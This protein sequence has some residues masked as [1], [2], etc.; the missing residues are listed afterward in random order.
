MRRFFSAVLLCVAFGGLTGCAT[1]GS[2]PKDPYEKFNR[3]MFSVNEGLDTVA[4][5]IAQGYNAIV[6]MPL[7]VVIGNFF[8]N[9]GDVWISVNN[10]LQGNVEKGF[11]DIGRVL[12][13]T[14]VGFCGIFDFAS[15]MG[16][17]KHSEDFGQTLG[18]WGVGSGPYFFWPVIGPRTA[19]D[20]LGWVIDMR[21]DPLYDM[22]DVATRNTLRGTRMLEGRARLLQAEGVLDA[23]AFDKYEYIR[24]LYLRS[25]EAAIKDED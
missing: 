12:I 18:K 10:F 15:E 2:N 8:G 20:T 6:P 9:L 19:R 21:A 22:R 17:E 23:A 25:R 7:R 24:D 1:T 13:N 5:P 16:L 11:S 14:T 4:K 3:T